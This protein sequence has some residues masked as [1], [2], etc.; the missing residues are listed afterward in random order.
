MAKLGCCTPSRCT[1]SDNEGKAGSPQCHLL[2]RSFPLPIFT[3]SPS[4]G[5]LISMT[6]VSLA[7]IS[8]SRT[9]VQSRPR[10]WRLGEPISLFTAA[11]QPCICGVQL[12]RFNPQAQVATMGL[13]TEILM[14][15]SR[16]TQ[17]QAG[18]MGSFLWSVLPVG[19]LL[20]ALG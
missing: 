6:P 2:P 10:R 17:S 11:L 14:S 15:F 9:G 8:R 4:M 20:V 19:L 12:L 5:L 18:K 3:T 13:K 1:D 16:G 7:S